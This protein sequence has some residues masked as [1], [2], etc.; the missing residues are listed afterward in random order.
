MYDFNKTFFL[1]IL[2]IFI[3]VIYV[4]D[5]FKGNMKWNERISIYAFLVLLITF[6]NILFHMISP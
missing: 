3:F 1:I 4:S 6:F 5:L 2:W